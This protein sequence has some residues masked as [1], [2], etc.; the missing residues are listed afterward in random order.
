[1]KMVL[2]PLDLLSEPRQDILRLLKRRGPAT[3]GE[4]SDALGLTVS[5]VRQHLSALESAGLVEHSRQAEGR[6]RPRHRY[7]PT[8]SGDALFPRRHA[9]LAGELLEYLEEESPETLAALFARRSRRRLEDARERLQGTLA[10]RVHELARI[11]DEDG[12]LAE[13]EALDPHG[14]L[15]VER[16]CAIL[17]IAQ[18]YAHPC[19]SEIDF[20]REA[21]PDAHVRRVSH[22][23]RGARTCAYEV[24]PRDPL[25]PCT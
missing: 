12:Y 3:A 5:G 17:S 9:E 6:G 16:N 23:V 11:L 7:A 20:L 1:M 21:L 13:V 18:R 2:S 8:P 4:L 24:L 25:P 14:F 19:S 22:I 10:Q 15:L